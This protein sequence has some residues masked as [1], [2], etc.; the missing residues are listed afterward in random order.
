[1]T[2]EATLSTAAAILAGCVG[3]SLAA[4]LADRT[5]LSDRAADALLTCGFLLPAAATIA[6]LIWLSAKGL[7]P[8]PAIYT[9]V[10]AFLGW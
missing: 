7:N 4:R 2:E 9:R 6:L 8:L 1:M 10:L 5:R 3:V